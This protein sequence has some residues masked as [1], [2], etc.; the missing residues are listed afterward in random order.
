MG[1]ISSVDTGLRG[2]RE[3]QSRS[4]SN[5]DLRAKPVCSH[6]EVEPPAECSL[7][8]LNQNCSLLRGAE[9]MCAV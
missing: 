7:D 2:M 4:K 5:P 8:E 1:S 9:E 6:L 3:N